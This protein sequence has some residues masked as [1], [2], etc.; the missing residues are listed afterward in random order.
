MV[1]LAILMNLISL[2]NLISMVN[3]VIL[4]NLFNM[5]YP[6]I[7]FFFGLSCDSGEFGDGAIFCNP[8]VFL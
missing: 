2:D 6:V 4:I 3:L 1:D 5:V 7:V 8:V